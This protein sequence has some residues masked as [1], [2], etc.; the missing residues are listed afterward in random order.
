MKQLTSFIAT[1]FVCLTTLEIKLWDSFCF[2]GYT[3]TVVRVR[4]RLVGMQSVI[5]SLHPQTGSM[6]KGFGGL[7][8]NSF[9]FLSIPFNLLLLQM[10]ISTN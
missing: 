9:H 5:I 8:Y 3:R 2:M 4:E 1:K 10:W 6:S 7:S